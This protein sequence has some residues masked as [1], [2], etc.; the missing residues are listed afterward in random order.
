MIYRRDFLRAL[1][2]G[3]GAVFVGRRW[4]QQGRGL[5]L[6]ESQ[7]LVLGDTYYSTDGDAWFREDQW[8]CQRVAGVSPIGRIESE[9]GTVTRIEGKPNH[10]RQLRGEKR[11]CS[12][13]E[14]PRTESRP[15]VWRG[16]GRGLTCST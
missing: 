16:M 15:V 2:L 4:Y 3:T 9:V 11:R 14:S 8:A 10:Y 7:V 13:H 6:P 12:P 5:V 1:A